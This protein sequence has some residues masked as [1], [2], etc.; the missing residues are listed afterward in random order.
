M[1]CLPQNRKV[2]YFYI[3][4][5]LSKHITLSILFQT[6]MHR[7]TPCDRHCAG[8]WGHKFLPTWAYSL[9]GEANT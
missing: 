3:A 9:E 6:N 8:H 5:Q 2:S 4:L 7:V 1:M